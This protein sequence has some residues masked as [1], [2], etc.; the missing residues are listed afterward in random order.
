MARHRAHRLVQGFAICA[1]AIVAAVV[2][3]ACGSSS[4]NSGSDGGGGST[5]SGGSASGISYGTLPAKGTRSNG[6][7]IT[8]GQITGSTPTYIFPIIPGTDASAYTINLIQNLFAPLYNGPKGAKPTIDYRSSIGN[9]P[10]YSDGGKTVTIML[11]QGYKW[12]NGAPVDANDMVFEIDAAE[13]GGEGERGELEP[14]HAGSVPDERAV[15]DGAVEVQAGDE[16]QQ[17]L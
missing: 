14:V 1:L 3:A 4:S 12:S 10:T 2:V 13:G 7:T 17:G 8:V 5:S 16:A 6:G 9:K 11:K 15:G